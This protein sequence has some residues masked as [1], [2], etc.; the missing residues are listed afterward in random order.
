MILTL[1]NADS[2]QNPGKLRK[3]DFRNPKKSIFFRIVF[4]TF[5]WSPRVV[6]GWNFDGAYLSTSRTCQSARAMTKIEFFRRISTKTSKNFQKKFKKISRSLVHKCASSVK[7]H[8]NQLPS[9]LWQALFPLAQSTE[10]FSFFVY[11]FTFSLR[12]STG[13]LLRLRLWG[14]R[15]SDFV[16]R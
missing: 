9:L 10:L 14:G 13:Y 2:L 8:S 12:K 15:S 16:S 5:W 6:G 11:L 4:S 1:K 7:R 3:T